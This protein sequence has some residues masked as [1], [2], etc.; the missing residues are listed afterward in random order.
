MRFR[1]SEGMVLIAIAFRR[2]LTPDSQEILDR[3]DISHMRQTVVR[4][5]SCLQEYVLVHPATLSD[6]ELERYT[7]NVQE[8]SGACGAHSACLEYTD[9]LPS[10]TQI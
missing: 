3:M 1:N 8:H 10:S 5:S 2:P 6:E 4:C 7:R 9:C